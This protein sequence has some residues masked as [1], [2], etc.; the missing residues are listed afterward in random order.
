MKNISRE[1]AVNLELSHYFTGEPCKH[2]HIDRRRVANRSC[3]A[4]NLAAANRRYAK[5]PKFAAETKARAANWAQENQAQYRARL[6]KWREDNSE[7][8]KALQKT[9]REE[10]AQAIKEQKAKHRKEHPEIYSRRHKNRYADPIYAAETKKRAK[11]WRE[12]NPEHSKELGKKWR[13]ANPEKTKLMR[14]RR[15]MNKR[16]RRYLGERI[17][18]AD[19]RDVRSAK[20]CA[21]CKHPHKHM[22]IDHVQPLSKGGANQRHNLQ[23][24]CRPC[25]R[26]KSCKDP[27]TWATERQATT[28]FFAA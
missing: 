23:L 18:L 28:K 2:G 1:Q 9:W 13:K 25:N 16:A 26:S 3:V 19:I 12:N 27:I 10:N 8:S 17:S 15:I 22:E 4:C 24:L 14:L 20:T 7:K 11:E 5:D 21:F 6:K